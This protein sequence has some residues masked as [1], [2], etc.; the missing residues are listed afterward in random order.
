MTFTINT[1]NDTAAVASPVTGNLTPEDANGDYSL[2]SVIQYCDANPLTGAWANNQYA[3]D[4]S[5]F[6]GQTLTLSSA[7]GFQTLTLS[8]NVNF[9][10]NDGTVEIARSLNA[11][12]PAFNHFDVAAPQMVNDETYPSESHFTNIA[13]FGGSSVASGGSIFNQ[14]TAVFVGCT[15]QE[16]TSASS[17][18]AIATLSGATTTANGCTFTFN[19]TTGQNMGGGAISAVTGS[20]A[21]TITNC[22]LSDN[23]T[24]G[25][26]GAVWA[27]GAGI[28][29]ISGGTI[30]F[31][32]ATTNGASFGGGV[33]VENTTTATISQV[34]IS[35]NTSASQGGGLAV[36]N[37]NLTMTGGDLNDNTAS[38]NGGGFYFGNNADATTLTL[39]QVSIT[40]NT[41]TNGFGGGGFAATGTLS[42]NLGAGQLTG[43]S[44]G[45]VGMQDTSGIGVA[46]GVHWQPLT[47]APGQQTIGDPFNP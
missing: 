17:G 27:Q 3:V 1:P 22:T 31:N 16:N 10:S 21:T 7:A 33:Y 30:S 12:T 2:R 26:G 11:G 5:A 13:F 14:G 40:N 20:V 45:G 23:E 4:L 39:N 46:P 6:G 28:L 35:D 47:I 38:S 29:S 42:G 36:L 9:Y 19:S 34:D 32:K 25:N 15:F 18:G 24:S 43:N 37:S 44:A 8:T 41:S